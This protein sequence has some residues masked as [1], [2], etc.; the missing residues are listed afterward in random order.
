[1]RFLWTEADRDQFL[2][3]LPS[4]DRERVE[5]RDLASLLL[6]P[7]E[8]ADIKRLYA[9]CARHPLIMHRLFRIRTITLK[10]PDAI[11]EDLKLTVRNVEW[12][13]MRIYRVRNSIVHRGSADIL[14]PQLTQHL[15]CYFIKTIKSILAELDRNPT[16]SIRNALEG[17][18]M[19]FNHAVA[20]FKDDK[21][22]EI[23]VESILDPHACMGPQRAPF[24]WPVPEEPA[25]SQTPA[26]PS[27]PPSH[28]AVE[29]ADEQAT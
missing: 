20:F 28:S 7:K 4:S 26:P 15:H 19:L 21:G 22:H 11:A 25:T 10:D 2:A 12:Q 9:F 29:S 23:S 3:L 16:W 17:R 13:L 5:I 18:R 6:L 24:A 27:T 8:H 1:M 14:L